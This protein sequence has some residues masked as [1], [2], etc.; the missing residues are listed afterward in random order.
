MNLLLGQFMGP[1]NPTSRFPR[2][3]IDLD[4]AS[5]ARYRPQYQS[6]RHRQPIAIAEGIELA[7]KIAKQ[8]RLSAPGCRPVRRQRAVLPG[9]SHF[10]WLLLLLHRHPLPLPPAGLSD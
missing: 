9:A 4:Q 8:T 10:R 3:P 6:D 2:Q 7:V 1:R 5:V